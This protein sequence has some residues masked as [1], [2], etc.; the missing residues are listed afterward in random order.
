MEKVVIPIFGKRIAPRLDLSKKVQ[1]FSVENAKVIGS[2]TVSLMCSNRLERIN[3]LIALSPDLI[4]CDGLSDLCK[5]EILKN[6]IRLI[7]WVH[8]EVEKVMEK[9]LSGEIT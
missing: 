1:L 9:Y 3:M 4:I 2:E 8:G 7:P 6:N 5:E